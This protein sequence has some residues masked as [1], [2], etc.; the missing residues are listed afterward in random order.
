MTANLVSKH[1]RSES[2]PTR[3]GYQGF[4]IS[5]TAAKAGYI[6]SISLKNGEPNAVPF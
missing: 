2:K 3:F 1:E 5:E 6:G 4:Y